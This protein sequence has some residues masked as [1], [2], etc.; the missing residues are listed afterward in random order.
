MP[1]RLSRQIFANIVS[2]HSPVSYDSSSAFGAP[3][4]TSRSPLQVDHLEL[5]NYCVS[6]SIIVLGA[7]SNFT[8]SHGQKLQ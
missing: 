4:L 7:A 3:Y 6:G 5:A 8:L 1:P 2:C